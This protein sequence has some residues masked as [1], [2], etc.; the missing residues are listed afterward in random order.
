MDNGTVENVVALLA[1]TLGPERARHVV[2]LEAR[3]LGL[4][5]KITDTEAISILKRLER[6]TGSVGLAAQLAL[7]K[8]KRQ[9][10]VN[11]STGAFIALGAEALAGGR[12]EPGSGFVP[13]QQLVALFSKSLGDEKAS[14]LIGR[15]ITRLGLRGSQLTRGDAG[16]LLDFLEASGGVTG[17]V[18][19]FAKVRFLLTIDQ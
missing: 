14:E 2:E 11:I 3:D 16:R 15:S 9:L 17:S 1:P 7:R 10:N 8:L 12:P 4:G 6:L 19:R 13:P 5:P 18:A